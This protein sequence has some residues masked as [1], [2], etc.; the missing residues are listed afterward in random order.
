VILVDTNIW[1][2]HLHQ[3]DETLSGLLDDQNF[4]IHPFVIGEVMLGNLKDRQLTLE[5]FQDMPQAEIAMDNEVLSLIDD[6]ELYGLG[7]GYVDAHL[8]ASAKLMPGTR[9]WTRDKRLAAAA[10]RLGLAFKSLH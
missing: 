3:A 6:H 4:W 10:E 2:D 5:F 1:I 9:V 8:L 7:I